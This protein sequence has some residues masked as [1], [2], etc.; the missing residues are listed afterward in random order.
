MPSQSPAPLRDN[1]I[2]E[3]A[4]GTSTATTKKLFEVTGGNFYFV[5]NK[6]TVNQGDMVTIILR[7]SFGTHDF[8]IDSLNAR[9]PIGWPG[10]PEPVTFTASQKGTFGYYSSV[11]SDRQNGMTGSLIVQ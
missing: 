8:V 3:L 7:N 11:A 9:T 2:K 1:Q 5:P 4:N 10:L 6:I